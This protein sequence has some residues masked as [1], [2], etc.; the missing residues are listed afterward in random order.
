MIRTSFDYGRMA[1]EFRQ[2]G[3]RRGA[4]LWKGLAAGAVAGLFAYGAKSIAQ[5]LISDLEGPAAPAKDANTSEEKISP[6][7][8]ALSAP[9][10]KE[11]AL[12]AAL[13]GAYGAAA[14][15]LPSV[16]QGAGLPLGTASYGLIKQQIIPGLD[17]TDLSTQFEG[18]KANAEMIAFMA[19]GLATEWLR[20]SIRK[21]L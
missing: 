9:S 19:F 2:V 17:S 4:N 6:V 7:Q 13:G 5:K 16:S 20:S 18:D 14:E 1:S 21:R 10:G 12:A 11:W 15:Y 8:Q 3:Q